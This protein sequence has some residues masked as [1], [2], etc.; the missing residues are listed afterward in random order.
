M[1]LDSPQ[2]ETEQMSTAIPGIASPELDRSEVDLLDLLIILAKRKDLIFKVTVGVA[3]AATIVC[4][5][6]PNKYTATAV[7]M[8]PQQSQSTA[9]MI[10]NQVAGA[11][12]LGSLA[13]LAGKDLGLKSNSGMYVDILKSRT[14]AD[15]LVNQFDLQKIYRDKKISDARK[16]L[17]KASD[18]SAGKN[19]LIE[20]KVE[21]YSAQ[22]AADLANAYVDE[23]HKLTKTLAFSEA[24]QRRLFFQ[25]EVEQAKENLAK[26]EVAMKDTEQRTGMI[27]LDT[28]AKAI[29]ESIGRL[30]AQIA[31]K[32]V[33]LRAMRS[34]ATDNNPQV[35][36]TEQELAG[37]QVELAK[38]EQQQGTTPEGDP[39]IATGR[40]PAY[41]L[42][43]AR[44]YREVRFR[45]TEFEFL[46][47]EL[48]AAKIDEAKEG[49]VIQV[50]DSAVPPDK[51]SWPRRW[52]IIFLS[53]FGAFLICSGY[54]I[55]NEALVIAAYDPETNSRFR[56]LKASLKGDLKDLTIHHKP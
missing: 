53:S 52:L 44:A 10:M 42:E 35:Q 32:Q 45:E 14:I 22:R 49:A 21:D 7:I 3:I 54:L 38:L 12:G 46:T 20:I 8:P 36:L 5:L 25:Q 55:A 29:I 16:E 9:S 39:I 13:A 41:G 33:V 2:T 27:H 34:F 30:Q 50:V 37:L 28:Q 40:L 17:G 24:S 19:G 47:K 4:F 18:I 56:E 23:L 6:L 51:K 43:W 1:K 31:A 26:A 11:G 15:A 48:E